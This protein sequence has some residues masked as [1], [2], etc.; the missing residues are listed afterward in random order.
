VGTDQ[1]ADHPSPT[2]R[3]G[4]R[5]W[6]IP[7]LIAGFTL[8]ILAAAVISLILTAAGPR[9]LNLTPEQTSG[10][11]AAFY[12]LPMIPTIWLS[13][14][15]RIP[16]AFTGNLFALIFFASLGTHFGFDELA[17]AAIVAGAIV[18][19]MSLLGLTGRIARWIPTPVVQGL[20]VG[21]IL[22]FLIDVFSAM[23]TTEGGA[24]VAFTVACVLVAYLVAD[25]FF[26]KIPAVV[27]AFVVGF[28]VAAATGLLGTI[29]NLF[30]LP[31]VELVA[32]AFS[33][34]AVLTVTPVLVA[35][36]VV[37][38]SVPSLIYLRN[39][40]FDPSERL[41]NVVSG[42]GTMIASL[43]GPVLLSLALPATLLGAGP[44]AGPRETRYVSMYLPAAFCVSVAVFAGT[45]AALAEFVPSVL[46]L[47]FAALA[48][49]P[50]LVAALRGVT[51][52]PL[53]LG[54]LF[55]LA[56]AMSEISLFDLGPF[57]WSLVIG[58]V[59]STVF[60]RSALAQH[61]AAADQPA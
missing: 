23:R 57:F 36:M 9:G 42:V 14:R 11:I 54:P 2:D 58:T 61:R 59:V 27:P 20:I 50:A 13:V 16:F 18:L 17:G 35:L 32:P 29:P 1:P 10:W 39:Q 41:V 4:R 28:V 56:I 3:G 19:V 53:V 49:I 38:S 60:E 25:R 15:Y 43:F 47:A 31:H 26:P 51:A 12:A 30:S 33:W 44:T 40:G 46:L 8:A 21:A 34:T 22:P 24:E 52:G 7:P 45:A 37:Q 48:L 5:S 6:A 55:A